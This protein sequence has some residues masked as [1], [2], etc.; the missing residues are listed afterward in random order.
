M[1]D[2]SRFGAG[3]ECARELAPGTA[4]YLEARDDSSVAGDCIVR[5]CERRGMRYHIGLEFSEESSANGRTAKPDKNH[6]EPDYYDVLQISPKADLETIHRVFRIMASRFHPDNPETGDVEE[7]LRLRRAYSVLSNP[8]RRAE[9]DAARQA[10]ESGPMPIFELKDFVTGVEAESN[11]RLGV[12]SLLYNQRRMDPEHPG[13]SLLDLEQRMG[14]PRE[15]L[16][17][18]MW[19]LRAK[20]FVSM[21]DNSDYALTAE[22]VDHVETNAARSELVIKLLKPGSGRATFS[23]TGTAGHERQGRSEQPFL[24][25][26]ASPK[27]H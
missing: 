25:G 12:L 23:R 9:Y 11:R 13:I 15:Y 27:A 10:R 14:F 22:G 3:I 7:F 6:A 18:T 5:H 26:S 8:E 20:Q 16:N 2:V 1:L 19:Y 4:V 17:F 24:L 21:A